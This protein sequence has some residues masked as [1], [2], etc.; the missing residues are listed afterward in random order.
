MRVMY[1]E[2]VLFCTVA[3]LT[4]QLGE[5]TLIQLSDDSVPPK[6]VN[7]KVCTDIIAA[8]DEM[9]L[10]KLAGRYKDVSDLQ[11]TPLLRR[12]A[13]DL[14]AYYLYSRRNKGDIEN[15]R[16]RYKDALKELEDIQLNKATPPQ[17]HAISYEY[18]TSKRA[19]Q[20]AFTDDVWERY[21]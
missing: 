20:R 4:E 18:R 6:A 5:R 14:C 21:L 11:T 7:D 8:A 10:S 13:V 17:Q 16:A 15:V 12:I 19:S 9:I 3:D 2:A 1:S